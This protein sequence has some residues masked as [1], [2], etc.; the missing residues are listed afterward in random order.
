M[1]A[2]A[3]TKDHLEPADLLRAALRSGEY[4]LNDEAIVLQMKKEHREER[5][6]RRSKQ[7]QTEQQHAQRKQH[8][9]SR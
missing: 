5:A 8:Q 7:Q 3:M 9:A 2:D 6:R 1:L 4:Q